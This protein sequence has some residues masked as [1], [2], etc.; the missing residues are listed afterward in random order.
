M[1]VYVGQGIFSYKGKLNAYFTFSPIWPKG[2]I[3]QLII[4]R[5]YELCLCCIQVPVSR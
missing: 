4:F 2:V 3:T 1:K 5:A